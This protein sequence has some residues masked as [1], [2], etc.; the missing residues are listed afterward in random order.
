M[1]ATS[2]SLLKQNKLSLRAATY[3]GLQVK[4]KIKTTKIMVAIAAGRW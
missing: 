3:E 4:E 2:D 1:L